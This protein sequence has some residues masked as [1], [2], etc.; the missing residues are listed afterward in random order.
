MLL[1]VALA[2]RAPRLGHV[3]VD[4]SGSARRP[5]STPRSRSTSPRCRGRTPGDW[6][7]RVAASPLVAGGRRR[8][9]A[10]APLRL[11]GALAVPRPL[12][13][14]RSWRSP[15]TCARCAPTRRRASTRRVL[16]AGLAPAVRRRARRPPGAGG[17]RGGAAPVRGRRR[18]PGHRQDDHRGADRRAAA[19]AGARPPRRAAPPLVALAAPTG[20]AAARLEEA[21]H[22]EARRS[23]STSDP[24]RA[25]RA[26]ASTLHRL[27]GWRPGA[28]AASA[29]TATSGSPTT[30]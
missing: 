26:A 5:P 6:V 8:S 21:V 3:H 1:A 11:L 27:L 12:L 14:A 20:K 4:L 19:R 25:A 7:A 15:P 9:G 13:G 23:T 30:S 28:T 10:S 22:A 29:T 24:R 17:R 2:V 18:R 16:D